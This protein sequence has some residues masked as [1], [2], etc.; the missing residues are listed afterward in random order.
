MTINALPILRLFLQ[1]QTAFD[2][3]QALIARRCCVCFVSA[4]IRL[5]PCKYPYA[6][7]GAFYENI[8]NMMY[9]PEV[10]V[11]NFYGEC[12]NFVPKL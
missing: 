11:L 10:V 5:H 12:A 4:W 1:C 6:R 2:S 9:W 8:I 7:K 3:P